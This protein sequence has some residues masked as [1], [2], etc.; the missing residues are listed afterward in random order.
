M[1][2][3]SIER[4]ASGLRQ[5]PHEYRPSLGV[6]PDISLD[7]IA[8]DVKVV[9][10][11]KESGKLE[12]P[13]SSSGSLDETEYAIIE[14]IFSDRKAAHH[15]LLDQLTT[16]TERLTAL[17]FH[18]R[19]TIIQNAAPAAVSEFG[20]EARQGRDELYRLRRTLLEHEQE[21]DDF[22]SYNRLRRAPRLSSPVTKFFKVSFLVFLFV[23]ETYINAVFLAKGNALGFIGGAA[24]ALV[25]ATLNVLTSF[26]IGLGGLRYLNHRNLLAKV[27]GLL[28]F[29]VWI[30]FAVLL[31]LALAHYRE[32]SGALYDD[33]GAQVI[34]RLWQTPVGLTDIKSWLFFG[35][36]L[37][38]SVLALIEGVFYTD[39][40]PGYAALEGRVRK[41]HEDYRQCKNEL[42][43]RLRD[44]QDDA[45]H[46]MEEAQNDLGK[47]R[48]AHTAI[49]AT[50]T[51]IIQ[52]FE[53]HQHQLERAGNALLSKYRTA[54]R[55]ARSSPPPSRFDEHWRMERKHAED[56]PDTLV[57][58]D[59]DQEIKKAQDLLRR[60]IL[61]IHNAFE[62]AVERYHQIDDL[63]PEKPNG[64]I[65][66]KP[67]GPPIK[68]SA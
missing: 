37:L 21:R 32:V 44:V 41:S 56:L 39:P 62:D 25:F 3:P 24:E 1:R 9:E 36:G 23:S 17:D 43:D 58:K 54:N 20:T 61:A 16:C 40:Y 10:K 34:T 49:L 5:A 29:L 65:P 13:T 51:R 52:L 33:A 55:Q 15:T 68:K 46:L 4:L 11:G 22:K 59:L 66:E 53:E 14:R 2:L 50:R 35:I 27:F 48:G 47:R 30:A 28:S 42:I 6:F 60:E 18:G 38:W 12:L 8:R 19:F 26:G 45:S 63:I 67:N 31:N 57:R 7:A 64:P